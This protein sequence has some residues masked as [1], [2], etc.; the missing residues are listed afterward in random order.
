MRQRVRED[1][2][3]RDD[4]KPPQSLMTEFASLLDEKAQHIAT[5]VGSG[6]DPVALALRPGE[7]IKFDVPN[8]FGRPSLGSGMYVSYET[9][10]YICEA[11]PVAL[12]FEVTSA[13]VGARTMDID[14]FVQRCRLDE[15]AVQKAFD[16][17]KMSHRYLQGDG[18]WPAHTELV[19]HRPDRALTLRG[20]VIGEGT[21]PVPLEEF[22]AHQKIKLHEQWLKA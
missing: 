21:Q 4:G 19:I 20:V 6:I 12:A 16:R 1:T 10:V 7:I 3:G 11:L 2:N 13:F 22:C 9:P 5:S 17:L 14:W 18:A 8:N 15:N